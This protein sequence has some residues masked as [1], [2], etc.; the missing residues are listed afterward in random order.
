MKK[1][2]SL[3][4]SEK[5]ENSNTFLYANM[6]LDFVRANYTGKLMIDIIV[7]GFD[8]IKKCQG[9]QKCFKTGECFL[10][11]K[12]YMCKIKKKMLDADVIILGCGVYFQ[13]VSSEMKNFIDRLAYWAHTFSLAGKQCVLLSTAGSNGNEFV[14]SY[15]K[16]VSMSLGMQVLG[17]SYCMV[18]YPSELENDQLLTK[19]ISCISEIIIQ[20]LKGNIKKQSN[21][22][23]ERLFQSMKA[24][25][26]T[27]PEFQY[28][29]YVWKKNGLFECSTF[30]DVMNL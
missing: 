5:K 18:E 28:E 11:K 4:G 22:F 6:I 12:D 8:E 26:S 9:C 7:V 25:F 3:I 21:D 10:D 17:T 30:E 23:Q 14:F 2:F 13:H 20:A 16:R 27:H 1:I 29:I 19:R 24:I 15:M